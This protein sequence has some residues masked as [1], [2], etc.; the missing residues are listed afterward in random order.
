MLFYLFLND[1]LGNNESPSL[2][3]DDQNKNNEEQDKLT[4][5]WTPDLR[6][7]KISS[8]VRGWTYS[9]SL[10]NSLVAPVSSGALLGT[11]LD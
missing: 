9:P 5:A 10:I 11:N 6:R 7:S 8:A 1:F 2:M 3:F 4:E